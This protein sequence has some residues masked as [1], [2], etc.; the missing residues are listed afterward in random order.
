M[1]H[2]GEINAECLGVQEW[3]YWNFFEVDKY[4][5]PILHNQINL[6]NYIFHNLLNWS[7][8]Y[9]KNLP[10]EE[11]MARYSLL[12]IDSSIDENIKLRKYFDIFEEG[13]ELISRNSIRRR[14][15]TPITTMI[16]AIF[17]CYL[18]IDELNRKR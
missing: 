12:M 6:G 11:D 7:N 5:C 3:S 8:E 2:S 10:L 13:K 14:Y 16:G 9:I 1:S 4:I 15:M 18:K 17:H